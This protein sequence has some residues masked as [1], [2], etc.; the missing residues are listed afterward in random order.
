MKL[1][2]TLVSVAL[3]G[4]LGLPMPVLADDSHHPDKNAGAPSTESTIQKMQA[5][6]KKMEEQLEKMAKT[7]DP[8]ERQLLLQQHM[9]TMMRNAAMAQCMTAKGGMG[10]MGGMMG[11]AWG[12]A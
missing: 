4:A 1:K 6:T 8:K 11:P 10:M 9:Q 2:T 5:N 3:F 7:K 12:W